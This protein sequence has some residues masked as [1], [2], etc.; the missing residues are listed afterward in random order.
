V[1]T[2]EMG[3]AEHLATTIAVA[4]G[5]IGQTEDAALV[6]GNDERG[7]PRQIAI[8]THGGLAIAVV[9]WESKSHGRLPAPELE[10]SYTPWREVRTVVG[11]SVTAVGDPTV[12]L[13]VNTPATGD[14]VTKSPQGRSARQP[15]DKMLSLVLERST[16]RGAREA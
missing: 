2:A 3:S 14:I 11:I 4:L 10:L 5:Q 6:I 15:F 12:T 13:T 16:G 7:T 9:D 1:K 8:A